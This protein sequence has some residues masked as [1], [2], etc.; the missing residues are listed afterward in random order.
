MILGFGEM[1]EDTTD[2]ALQSL[3]RVQNFDVSRLAGVE[4]LGAEL[5]FREAVEPANRVISLFNQFPSQYLTELPASQQQ[6]MKEQADAFYNVLEQILSFDPKQSDAYGARTA[7]ISNVEQQY[8]AVFKALSGLIAYGASRLRDFSALERDAR[9]SIQA[10]KDRADD[11]TKALEGQQAE[12]ERILADVRRVAAEQGVSQQAIYF[13]EEA[14]AHE[15]DAEDWRW[16]TIYVAAAL[17]VFAVFSIFLHKIPKLVP[18]TPYD[19]FQLGLSKILIFGVIAYVLLL[20][21]RNFLSHK[22]NAI[23]NK[24]RYNALLTF[25]ALANAANGPEPR[26]IVLSYAAA[27]IFSPQDTGYV[28]ANP[29]PEVP[30][31]LVQTLPRLVGGTSPAN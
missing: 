22:H 17:V 5:N 15:R 11:A 4:R 27:C 16:K 6:R 12:A 13:K 24:H 25:T 18:E 21:A 14:E 28:K 9:A 31:G 8:D 3:T 26:D 7:L 2:S 19:A 30:V 20:C 29:A 10:A 23:V 1:A